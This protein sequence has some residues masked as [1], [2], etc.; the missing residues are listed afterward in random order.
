ML[1]LFAPACSGMGPLALRDEIVLINSG[2]QPL[3]FAAAELVTSHRIDPI[4][5]F[6]VGDSLQPLLE[7]GES[8]A[9][10]GASITGGYHRGD[11][12]TVFVYTVTDSVANLAGLL[13]LTAADLMAR[14]Y[15]V[16]IAPAVA[17]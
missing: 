5:S 1:I 15:R 16:D 9:L 7:S 8:L 6:A 12:V 3:T 17:R 14:G 11:G 10:T 2:Y 13:Q 4:P